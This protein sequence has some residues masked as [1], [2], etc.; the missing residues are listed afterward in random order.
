MIEKEYGMEREAE[1]HKILSEG[2][3]RIMEIEKANKEA[4]LV[5]YPPNPPNSV[6]NH[7]FVKGLSV[8]NSFKPKVGDYT[9]LFSSGEEEM[10]IWTHTKDKNSALVVEVKESIKNKAFWKNLLYVIELSLSFVEA[11]EGLG[12]SGNSLEYKWIYYF[13]S[14]KT[15]IQDAHILD[16]H[17][18]DNRFITD[19]RIIKATQLAHMS[20]VIE[21]LLRDDKA[22]VAV[23]TLEL[24]FKMHYICLICEL[25]ENPY[26]DHLSLEPK[27]WE[28]AN[29][30]PN[31]EAA[32]V[33]ACR[34]VESILGEPPNRSKRSSVLKHKEKWKLLTEIDPDGE[35]DKG[36]VS[37][38][39]YYYN[40]F[41]DLR[42]PSAHSYG[43]IQFELEREKT[44]QAQCFAALIV[45]SY[46]L[47]NA[48]SKT[49]AMEKLNFNQQLIDSVL[50]DMSTPLT[51]E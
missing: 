26:H 39:D 12:W 51:K 38:F 22:F 44:I 50:E 41:Y 31:M 20:P 14:S 24:S 7:A 30:I 43:N 21:L 32:I 35:F 3:E 6:C 47:K 48:S 1:L 15:R 33:Q 11:F 46:I 45:Q 5:K 19:G 40:L 42:N 9:F 25:S 34:S 37:Y 16:T 23:S 10:F 27:I 18:D 28:A 13:N 2:F 29:Y 49:S 17:K 36:G 4:F 8:E